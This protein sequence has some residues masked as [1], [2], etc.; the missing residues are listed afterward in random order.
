MGNMPLLDRW[1]LNCILPRI[2]NENYFAFLAALD[3]IVKRGVK[4]VILPGDFSDDG[5][6]L[7]IRG[8]KNILDDYSKKH[9]INFYAITGNHDPVKPFSGEAGKKDFLGEGGK[10]QPIMSKAG[11]YEA[12]VPFE[13]PTVVS[14]DI[15]YLGYKEVIGQLKDYGFYPQ[16]KHLYW[17]TPFSK[18]TYETYNFNDA[19]K[20]SQLKN[21]TYQIPPN[22]FNVPDVSYLVEPVEGIW[23]LALDAN[24][25]IPVK[26]TIDNNETDATNYTVLVLVIIMFYLIKN[27]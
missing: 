8:L 27:I 12:N 2:F 6:P 23:L 13:H 25:Y 15:K 9:G 21:R 5:Q 18:Y 17:E 11:M 22:N 26:Q 10:L 24:V 20:E 3:D 1:M 16:K 7:N 14:S 19:E 4:F